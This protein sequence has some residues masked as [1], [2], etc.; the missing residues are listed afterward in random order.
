MMSKSQNVTLWE[1]G[2]NIYPDMHMNK[3]QFSHHIPPTWIRPSISHA[4]RMHHNEKHAKMHRLT[5]AKQNA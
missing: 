1:R 3:K 2:S 5:T 4:S